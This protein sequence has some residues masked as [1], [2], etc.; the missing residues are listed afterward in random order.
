LIGEGE[1]RVAREGRERG[2]WRK[3]EEGERRGGERERGE[4]T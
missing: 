2:E 1:R 4:T 3:G